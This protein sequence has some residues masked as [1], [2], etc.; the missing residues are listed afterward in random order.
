MLKLSS[1]KVIYFCVSISYQFYFWGTCRNNDFGT[2]IC[3]ENS[4]FN[5][6]NGF[7]WT[8]LEYPGLAS[9]SDYKLR[10]KDCLNAKV[11]T[12]NLG[13]DQKREIPNFPTYA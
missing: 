13:H 5:L 8:G 9:Q 3:S 1:S 10:V 11:I 2:K 6:K 7:L 12:D 4:N